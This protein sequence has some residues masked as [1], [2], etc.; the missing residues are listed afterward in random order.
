MFSEENP[1]QPLKS[2]GPLFKSGSGDHPL[3]H[4]SKFDDNADHCNP[5]GRHCS[6]PWKSRFRS[7]FSGEWPYDPEQLMR[8][9]VEGRITLEDESLQR[10]GLDWFGSEDY[11]VYQN[12]ET[13]ELIYALCSKRGNV[14]HCA[15]KSE[16]KKALSDAIESKVFDWPVPGT[17]ND[18]MTR[19]LFVTLTFDH[20]IMSRE[21][22][23]AS[24][25]ANEIPDCDALTGVVNN[26][27]AN[28]RSI[29]GP[30]CKLICKEANSSGWPAPHIIFLLEEPVR[31]RYH[32]GRDGTVTWRIVDRRILRRIGKDPSMRSLY[33]RNH[34]AAISRNPIWSYGLFDV[35]GI[36][37]NAGFGRYRNEVTYLF[38]YLTKCFSGETSD[39]ISDLDTINEAPEKLRT[40][41]YTHLANKCFRTRDISFGKKFKERV[42]LLPTE[43]DSGE[44]PWRRLRTIPGFVHEDIVKA[45]QRRALKKL[46]ELYSNRE[47]SS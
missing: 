26:L 1:I 6:E 34:S 7:E 41:L 47:S 39:L 35:Q 45:E 44:S 12:K 24:L 43:K 11:N 3:P 28:M 17:R 38:K 32:K 42:G 21:R 22:A 30:L 33:S 29:F 31:V 40:M 15:R 10:T 19:L 5:N 14:V 20:H 37:K 2:A 46:R 4:F 27:E 23:W 36:I 9:L 8:D 13:G 18:H 16:Q 25:R